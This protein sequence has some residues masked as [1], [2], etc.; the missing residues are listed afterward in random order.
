MKTISSSPLQLSSVTG[1]TKLFSYFYCYMIPNLLL[2]FFL[3]G[4]SAA[5]IVLI[6]F[7]LSFIFLINKLVVRL[8][9]CQKKGE[10]EVDQCFLW[11]SQI[12][13]HRHEGFQFTV[14]EEQRNQKI[15]TLKKLESENLELVITQT[16]MCCAKF[17]VVLFIT[18]LY[19]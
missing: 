17:P 12:Y 18:L 1:Y 8:I 13:Q 9:K 7:N 6:Q 11:H 3:D 14:T 5:I 15:F 19:S 16:E 2:F 4:K 10:K